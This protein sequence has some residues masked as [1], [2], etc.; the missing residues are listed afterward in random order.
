MTQVEMRLIADWIDDGVDAA[1]RGDETAIERIAGEVRELTAAF[2][3]PGPR[4]DQATAA[5]ISRSRQLTIP[6]L[7]NDREPE[8]V[9]LS[10]RRP[11]ERR[12]RDLNPRRTQ[13]P[14]V[15][16]TG[17]TLSTSRHF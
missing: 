13:R 2:P 14:D 6:G 16:E 4:A 7:Q 9:R 15:F 17:T 8:A 1:G 11:V 3:P 12:G 5:T 10:R